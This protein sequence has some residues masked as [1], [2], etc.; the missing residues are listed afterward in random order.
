M[1]E[2]D[3]NKQALAIWRA[4][5]KE[6]ALMPALYPHGHFKNNLELLILGMNPAFN[7]DAIQKRLS[8]L[9]IGM[10]ATDVFRWSPKEEPR[11]VA[12]LLRAE[13]DAFANYGTYFKPL[14]EFADEI[15]CVHSY[16]HLDLFHWRHTKQH[17]FTPFVGSPDN[18]NE[19]GR[20]QIAL[21]RVMIERLRPKV[22]VI[23]NAA[24]ARYAVACMPLEYVAGSRTQCTLPGS[25]LPRFFLS[26]MLSGMRR[27]DTFSR[28]R[29]EVDVR[30]YL[31]AL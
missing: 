4:H 25:T 2:D 29:L 26:G 21:T 27:M 23:A 11:Y 3:F 31:Q 16:S 8:G 18:L 17:E 20:A 30:D 19:F 1:I 28:I 15:G 24:A 7:E 13:L 14:R 9:G 10:Q 6:D 12:E 5:L 22:V